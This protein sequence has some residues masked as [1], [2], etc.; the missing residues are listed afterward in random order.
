MV[1]SW[2][3]TVPAATAGKGRPSQEEGCGWD[4][5]GET[6]ATGGDETELPH[7]LLATQA[8]LRADDTPTALT[9]AGTEL[10]CWR[11]ARRVAGRS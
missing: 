4:R 6:S 5:R 11:G 2:G 3:C 8:G 9:L 7:D 1:A 10:S